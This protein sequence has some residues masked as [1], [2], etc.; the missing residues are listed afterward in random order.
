MGQTECY[1]PTAQS[2]VRYT[3]QIFAAPILCKNPFVNI[4]RKT[5]DMKRLFILAFIFL[6]AVA[7]GQQTSAD[8]TIKV[9]YAD[10]TNSEKKPAFFINGKFAGNF[11]LIKTGD[12][13]SMSIVSGNLQVDSIKYYGQ[14][15]LFT[16]KNYSPKLIS[17]TAVKEKYTNLG[18]KSVV[19]TIDGDI[20]NSDYD[21]YFVDEN[22]L[23][24]IVVDK[25]IIATENVD[26][27]LIKLLT[28]S[29]ENFQKLKEC[30]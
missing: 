24:Q 17:L 15:H 8:S 26:L 7:H 19:F 21:K 1:V 18:N 11:L 27:G 29:E 4:L 9:L 5:Y 23:L 20:I 30:N 13:D 28:K 6:Y 14:I 22:Y 10:K 2:P 12:I 25:I 16:K 3:A